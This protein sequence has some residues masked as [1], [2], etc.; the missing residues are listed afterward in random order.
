[1]SSSG[2]FLRGFHTKTVCVYIIRATFLYIVAVVVCLD[3]EMYF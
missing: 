2:N 1:M 3:T